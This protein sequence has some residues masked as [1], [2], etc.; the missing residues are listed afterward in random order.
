MSKQ[1][2]VMIGL[3]TLAMNF[4]GANPASSADSRDKTPQAI[5]EVAFVSSLSPAQ[6]QAFNL[7]NLDQRHE[8]LETAQKNAL[9]AD[10]AVDTIMNKYQLAVVGGLLKAKA[11]DT[12]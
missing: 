9:I 10:A 2:I 3:I 5:E 7:M 8:V 11:A 12:K 6:C 1:T 4:V